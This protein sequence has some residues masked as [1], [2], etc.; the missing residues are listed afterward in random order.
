MDALAGFTAETV[1]PSASQEAA[2]TS[3]SNYTRAGL[4]PAYVRPNYNLA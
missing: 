1:Q 2:H 3:Y 4:T